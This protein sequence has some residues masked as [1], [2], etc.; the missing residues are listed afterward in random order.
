M[1]SCKLCICSPFPPFIKVPFLHMPLSFFSWSLFL[2][3]VV[4]QGSFGHIGDNIVTLFWLWLSSL[5]QN[6]WLSTISAFCTSYICI[7]KLWVPFSLQ[8]CAF[9]AVLVLS[10]MFYPPVL[11]KALCSEGL[12][13]LQA[14]CQDSFI[15]N[16]ALVAQFA[17]DKHDFQ[18]VRNIDIYSHH[19]GM[20]KTQFQVE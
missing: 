16:N 20:A 19:F 10:S 12:F 15:H 2:T 14:I 8:P 9:I 5:N 18:A 1:S 11:P 7:L 3:V 6:F 17:L 4:A 13:S